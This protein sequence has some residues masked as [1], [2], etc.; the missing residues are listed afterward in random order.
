LKSEFVSTV[1]HELRTPLNVI[2]GY[3]QM[4]RDGAAGALNA[5]QLELFERVDL[6]TREL[7]ELIEATLHVGRLETGRDAVI[8]SRVS[9]SDL[10]RALEASTA[11]LPRPARVSVC[12][13]LPTDVTGTI[14][15]DGAK[16][17]LIVRNLVSNALKFTCDGSV[18]VVVRPRTDSLVIEVAD[19]GIGIAPDH[20]PII[21]EM[22]RQLDTAPTRRHGGVGLGLYIVKQFVD[23]L[24]GTVEVESLPGKG[25]T[26]RVVLPG[27]SPGHTGG[28]PEP[29]K[30]AENVA[31]AA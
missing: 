31:S 12:W 18:T 21:F 19:T 4:L 8:L 15:T 24:H 23:R 11:G 10:A 5:E 25:S 14:M 29:F 1:S 22:F 9:M 16:V 20:V 26:F 7:L 17:A 30:T 2:I 28:A 27:Y 6:R 3:T 13:K